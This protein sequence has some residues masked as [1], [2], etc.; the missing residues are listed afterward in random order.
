VHFVYRN[1]DAMDY[2]TKTPFDQ[3]VDIFNNKSAK[4]EWYNAYNKIKHDRAENFEKANLKNL[5]EAMSGLFLLNVIHKDEEFI[6]TEKSDYQ[7]FEQKIN[8][9]SSVF[10]VRSLRIM[11]KR[12]ILLV[13]GSIP[14]AEPIPEH[15][16]FLVDLFPNN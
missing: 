5:V 15:Y 14:K 10:E 7:K 2:I 9:V 1:S 4:T 12:D 6:E 16:T 3:E 11:P 8:S 13:A